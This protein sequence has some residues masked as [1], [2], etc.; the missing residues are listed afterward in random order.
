MSKN[1]GEVLKEVLHIDFEGTI[2]LVLHLCSHWQS[3]E[4]QPSLPLPH[5]K[6]LKMDTAV[7]ATS[8]WH[9]ILKWHC[10]NKNERITCIKSDSQVHI[11]PLIFFKTWSFNQFFNQ[12]RYKCILFAQITFSS[13][14]KCWSFFFPAP[15]GTNHSSSLKWPSETRNY[16]FFI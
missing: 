6:L 8:L 11:L 2:F 7:M 5:G 10:N 13:F 1:V 12:M 15:L 9:W 16:I 4:A 14:G 3:T